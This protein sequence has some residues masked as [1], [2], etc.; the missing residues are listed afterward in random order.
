[1]LREMCVV[2]R[3]WIDPK[4]FEDAIATT[5][6]LPGPASTQLAIYCAWRLRG[7]LG[8]VIGGFCFIVP[9]L[10]LILGLSALFLMK[11]PP[12]WIL[13][14]A[15]GAGAAVP[16]VALSAAW[17]L[18]P[19][20]IG[21]MGTRQV[22]HARWVAYAAVGVLTAALAGSFLVLS[23]LLCGVIEIA[24]RL[25]NSPSA[26]DGLPALMPALVAPVVGGIGALGWV[27]LKVGALSY[28]GGFVIVPLMQHDAVTAYHWMTGS[29]FLNAVALGQITPGPVVQ[30]VAVIGYAASGLRGGLLAATVAFTPSFL[31]VLFGAPHLARIRENRSIQA[32]LTGA[33]PAVVGAIGGSAIPL[34]LAFVQRWQIAILAGALVWLFVA[35]RGVLPVLLMAAGVGLVLGTL[36]VAV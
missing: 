14:S 2:Q 3:E 30:T 33:G 25:R 1:M 29:Q 24:V 11:H 21:R 7:S 5:N 15:A 34:G 6:L 22:E 8:A 35:R 19:P 17:G 32:F 31:F 26:V 4:E 18:V 16:A 9:G 20:S 27:A 12:H 13:G 36:G 10:I 28:G 23:I